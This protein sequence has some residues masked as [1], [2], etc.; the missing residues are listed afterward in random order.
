MQLSNL[1]SGAA[2]DAAR[3]DQNIPNPFNGSSPISYY[4]PS[5]IQTAQLMITDVSG[6]VLKTYTLSQSGYGKQNILSSELASG[7]YRY[8]LLL[9]GK[10]IDTKRVILSR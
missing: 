7:T 8:S 9:D 4:I 5:G 3:L 1:Q 6:H 10:L 2:K